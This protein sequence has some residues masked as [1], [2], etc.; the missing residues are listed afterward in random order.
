MGLSTE[1]HIQMLE[2]LNRVSV[3]KYVSHE[4][5]EELIVADKHGNK[6]EIKFYANSEEN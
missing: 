4:D 1:K 3:K 2:M 6:M 5:Y